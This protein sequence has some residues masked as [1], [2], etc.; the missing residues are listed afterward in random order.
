MSIGTAGDTGLTLSGN[1]INSPVSDAGVAAL[2]AWAIQHPGSAGQVALVT[3]QQA[4][5]AFATAPPPSSGIQPPPEVHFDLN[6]LQNGW[7]IEL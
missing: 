2:G 1:T 7:T 5:V 6:F 4:A 3:P